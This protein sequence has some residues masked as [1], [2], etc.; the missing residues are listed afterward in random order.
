VRAFGEADSADDL[1][2]RAAGVRANKG[3]AV[4]TDP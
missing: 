3:P 2:R 1:L 4:I